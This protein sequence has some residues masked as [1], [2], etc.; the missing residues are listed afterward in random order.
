MLA[1]QVEE[2]REPIVFGQEAHENRQTTET[3]V[4]RQPERAWRPLDSV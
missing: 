1:T 4:R 3:R 2:M